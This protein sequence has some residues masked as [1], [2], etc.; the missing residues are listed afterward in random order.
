LPENLA[1]YIEEEFVVSGSADDYVFLDDRQTVVVTDTAVDWRTR[2]VIRR[3][4]VSDE[5]NGTVMVE[6]LNPTAAWDGTPMW[7]LTHDE[8]T[9]S[10]M[11]WV[12]VTIKPV[13][14]EFLMG[15]ANNPA[16]MRPV[17]NIADRY[18]GLDLHMGSRDDFSGEGLVW[19]MMNLITA[20]L[21]ANDRADHPL[22]G[23][24]IS[25]VMQAGYSQSA[26]YLV[27]HANQF[28]HETAD[29]YFLAA[30]GG[31]HRITFADEGYDWPDP[32]AVVEEIPGVPIVRW[33]SETEVVAFGRTV[34]LRPSATQEWVRWWEIAGGAHAPVEPGEAKGVRDVAGFDGFGDCADAYP[35]RPQD[36][37][38][39]TR[40]VGHA[41]LR[42]LQGWQRS[43]V[44]PNR[45][46]EVAR[47]PQDGFVTL[48]RDEV[49]NARG[50]VRLPAVDVPTATYRG[51]NT[52]GGFC[53]LMGSRT[54]LDL[55]TMH[56]LYPT[57]E[58]YVG[59]VEAAIGDA[60]TSGFL[61]PED[62]AILRKQ[63]ATPPGTS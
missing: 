49:G 5:A 30:G 2:V 16:G 44:P 27:T 43:E 41:T 59:K 60:I 57:H 46:L 23:Y 26:G 32:R 1:G 56:T 20:E 21:R 54:P 45:F 28:H 25:H 12:G 8:I 3:P 19:D 24:P 52:G 61:V 48:V 9:R 50:G 15:G 42:Y 38:V 17:T 11:V 31:A 18:A 47:V 40:F 62:A 29:S 33:Q 4:A 37:G 35:Q 51:T 55:R 63:A 53:Y 13:A 7:D 14:L 22:I 6:W 34:N 36:E 39:Q 58:S 10:G